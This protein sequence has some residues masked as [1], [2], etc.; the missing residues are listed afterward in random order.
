MQAF[1]IESAKNL[2]NGIKFFIIRR[3]LKSK[4]AQVY[5]FC[6]KLVDF[7]G[8]QPKKQDFKIYSLKIKV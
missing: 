3:N 6:Q 2:A 5:M 8:K 4:K 1:T 7:K